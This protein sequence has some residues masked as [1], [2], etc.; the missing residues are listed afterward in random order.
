MARKQT[1]LTAIWLE[2]WKESYAKLTP[3]R[4][5]AC[6]E[7]AMALVKQSTSTGLR[8][9]PIHPSKYYLEA[10]INSG[11]RIVFRVAEGT[12]YFVDVVHHDD[13]SR[14]GKRPAR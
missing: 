6:D 14:Y 10:R 5:A 13:I 11:D 1:F 4:Q 3:E 7:A 12:V 2:S 9:K 8:I